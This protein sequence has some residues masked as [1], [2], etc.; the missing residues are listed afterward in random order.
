MAGKPRKSVVVRETKETK[1]RVALNLDGNGQARLK[2]PIP[3]LEHMLTLLSGHGLLDL[4]ISAEGDLQVDQ[5]H[6][7]EDLGITLGQALQKAVGDKKGMTRYGACLLPMDETLVQAVL[8]FSG[9][10]FL[11]Y[12]LHVRQKR[13]GGFDTEL[14][15]EFFRALAVS[16]GITLHLTQPAGGNTHHVVEAAFKGVGRALRQ[17]LALDPR[18][19][20]IP[21]TKGRL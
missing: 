9:R 14:V 19:K 21:S 20:G 6:L 15:P 3:F 1:I 10:P 12:G 18:V 11:A 7:T 17:A 8:D 13:L 16:A 2:I 4:E 5:H